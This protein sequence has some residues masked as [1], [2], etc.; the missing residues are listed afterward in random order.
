[1]WDQM[2]RERE[3]E[4]ER[5]RKRER[6]ERER[7]M[8]SELILSF[9][10]THSPSLSLSPLSLYL[11][12]VSGDTEL[13]PQGT[14]SPGHQCDRLGLVGLAGTHSTGAGLCLIRRENQRSPACVLYDVT[15]RSGEGNGVC[16]GKNP[17][18]LWPQ[19]WWLSEK[20][21]REREREGEREGAMRG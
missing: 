20:R 14:A 8:S 9:T 19:Q 6:E 10:L 13:W 1:M 18:S 17:M 16:G 5:K 15:P 12:S 7:E 4:R 21:E 3:R 2:V 11:A